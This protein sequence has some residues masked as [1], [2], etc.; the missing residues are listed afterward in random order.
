M[1]RDKVI[2]LG[3]VIVIITTLSLMIIPTLFIDHVPL[4]L[5]LEYEGAEAYG[6]LY[7][8]LPRG[9]AQS[10]IMY[11]PIPENKSIFIDFPIARYPLFGTPE[12]E[13]GVEIHYLDQWGEYLTIQKGYVTVEWD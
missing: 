4:L 10:S 6:L 8:G 12:I 9:M 11:F 1:N 13:R 7:F 2:T 5:N 3:G